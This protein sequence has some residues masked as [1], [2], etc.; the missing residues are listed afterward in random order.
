MLKKIL[1]N[2]SLFSIILVCGL[3]FTLIIPAYGQIDVNVYNIQPFFSE[4]VI[5]VDGFDDDWKHKDANSIS[6]EATSWYEQNPDS[7]SGTMILQN[8]EQEIKILMKIKTSYPV[9]NRYHSF[10][11]VFDENGDGVNSQGDNI[12]TVRTEGDGTKTVT[13]D[14]YYAG[15]GN[16]EIDPSDDL[17]TSEAKIRYSSE[18]EI[19]LEATIPFR[20]TNN[21]YDIE[22]NVARDFG[23]NF[24]YQ[25]ENEDFEIDHIFGVGFYYTVSQD[26][27][28]SLLPG[29]QI[30]T[31]FGAVT[32]ASVIGASKISGKK[33]QKRI[34]DKKSIV[35]TLS[36]LIV[37]VLAVISNSQ[38]LQVTSSFVN[39]LTAVVEST[40]F[41][42]V[43]AFSILL[44]VIVGVF[45]H[46]IFK[47]S[48][49]IL[50]YFSLDQKILLYSCI[51]I[52]VISILLSAFTPFLTSLVVGAKLL[53]IS[54]ENFELF[55][56][57]IINALDIINNLYTVT[58]LPSLMSILI[59]VPSLFLFWLSREI[60]KADIRLSLK[61]LFI[62]S[63]VISFL[64]FAVWSTINLHYS[65]P[66][67]SLLLQLMIGP[68]IS[69][70]LISFLAVEG[71]IDTIKNNLF[72]LKHGK[73]P[74][75]ITN[76]SSLKHRIFAIV[77]LAVNVTGIL[78][79]L[80]L[81][82]IP[83]AYLGLP[84]FY[85]LINESFVG[86]ITLYAESNIGQNPEGSKFIYN[87]SVLIFSL[88]WLYDI[89]MILKGFTGEYLSSE[90]PIY[91]FIHKKIGIF[92]GVA[93][94]SFIMIFMSFQ[95][96][97]LD[98]G[99]I[100]EYDDFFPEWVI[101]E[102][103]LQDL[104]YIP[105][106]DL[107]SNIDFVIGIVTLVGIIYVIWKLKLKK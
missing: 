99:R 30:L 92:S 44:G 57:Q 95:S 6:F 46:F 47:K 79:Y 59:W 26:P 53:Q 66:T 72:R 18:K 3:A 5:I 40:S 36:I 82:T 94:L 22:M 97:F 13:Q 37:S 64:V 70:I 58:L 76:S 105:L 41:L 39:P 74:D 35:V 10:M 84:E 83:L 69:S 86:A 9:E 77:A 60:K 16:M 2:S 31:L 103:G 32:L 43:A 8:N 93:F 54:A 1:R 100:Y 78:R 20:D 14:G 24:N 96:T 106:G 73:S 61:I 15:S 62:V 4:E 81:I 98:S 48:G 28:V 29:M 12:L 17:K 21:F 42:S 52:F 25:T 65:S 55:K 56:E 107:S 63:A 87:Y 89:A 34:F 71:Y 104:S 67:E 11:L 68:A 101:K 45:C 75:D 33:I 23:I 49:D 88:F 90:N 91:R 51:G 38:F 19:I 80:L 85:S 27:S 50:S 102:Q 7:I